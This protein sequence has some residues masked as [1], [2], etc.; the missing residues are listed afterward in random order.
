[1]RRKYIYYVAI[2][3][4]SFMFV[5]CNN[6]ENHIIFKDNNQNIIDEYYINEET[7]IRDY[8]LSYQT[9]THNYTSL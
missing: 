4:A 9:K 8:D 1:M 7:L 2:F 3:F 5:G 6:N